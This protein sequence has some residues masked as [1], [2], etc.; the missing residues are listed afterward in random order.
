MKN[1]GV[2]L[3]CN[4]SMEEQIK[5]SMKLCYFLIRNVGKMRQYIKEKNVNNLISHTSTS[6]VMPYMVYLIAYCTNC[7]E[8]KIL[9]LDT[10][11]PHS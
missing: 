3:D 9:L 8:F 2:F 10:G 7:K 1:S 6:T 4:M 11:F 5:F